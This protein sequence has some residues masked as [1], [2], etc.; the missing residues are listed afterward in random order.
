MTSRL[1]R[2][3]IRCIYKNH[4]TLNVEG[5]P[6]QRCNNSWNPD[7]CILSQRERR[8]TFHGSFQKRFPFF[9]STSSCG[10]FGQAI[11]LMA[12]K[13]EG[14]EITSQ[15]FVSFRGH[16]NCGRSLCQ[17]KISTLNFRSIEGNHFRY[18][19]NLCLIYT[20]VQKNIVTRKWASQGLHKGGVLCTGR[21]ARQ[22]KV[23]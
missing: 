18:A 21:S 6:S 17:K 5:N 2:D 16:A 9:Y 13:T 20:N 14:S 23:S 12:F 7:H 19:P 4:A 22:R 11:S 15:N 1:A 3:K 8:G 10:T